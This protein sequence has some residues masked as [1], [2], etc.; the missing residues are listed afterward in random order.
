MFKKFVL[1]V[2]LMLSFGANA[3]TI[4]DLAVSLN[5]T[6][7]SELAPGFDWKVGDSASYSLNMGFV[8]GSMVMTITGLT[9]DELTLQQDL[10][11]G[12]AGKQNCEMKLNPNT[13]EA[14]SLVCNGKPQQVPGNDIEVIDMKD[15]QVTVPA[16]TFQSIHITAKQRSDGKIIDQWANPKAVPVMGMIKAISPGP[17]GKVTVELTSFKKN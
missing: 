2:G 10:D 3:A 5:Q 17:F 11:L 12:F 7:M 13:G 6:L 9:A 8:K 16:G 15:E 1:A 4:N 14:K